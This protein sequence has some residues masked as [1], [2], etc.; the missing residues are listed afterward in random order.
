MAR[1]FF[2]NLRICL[3]DGF[4][5]SVLFHD[6]LRRGHVRIHG[7]RYSRFLAT[8]VFLSNV[9]K[10]LLWTGKVREGYVEIHPPLQT[11]AIGGV[12]G[13]SASRYPA[14]DVVVGLEKLLIGD[15]SD[16]AVQLGDVDGEFFVIAACF[17][18]KNADGK[19]FAE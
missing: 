9:V 15:G 11:G 17:V 12:P 8:G 18:L 1:D 10:R 4:F 6:E 16:G 3:F 14:D 7:N 19:G 5:R 2:R 13:A